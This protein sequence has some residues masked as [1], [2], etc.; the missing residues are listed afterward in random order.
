MAHTT[1]ARV[2]IPTFPVFDSLSLGHRKEVE[3]LVKELSAYGCTFFGDL[4]AWDTDGS[5]EVSKLNNNLVVKLLHYQGEQMVLS[6]L[7]LN[8]IDKTIDQLL[9]FA[10]N[11]NL[12]PRLDSVPEE[13]A[14]KIKAKAGYKITESAVNNE[15]ILDA[16]TTYELPGGQFKGK[17]KQISRLQKQHPKV[18]TIL[19]DPA[20]KK[21]VLEIGKVMDDWA[22][23]AGSERVDPDERIAIERALGAAPT[24]GLSIIGCRDGGRLIAF[25]I[26]GLINRD[27]GVVLFEKA[28]VDYP[29]LYTYL[30]QIEARFFLDNG[31]KFIN[32][33]QDLGIAGIRASKMGWKPVKILKKF[34]LSR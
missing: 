32:I 27:Y 11:N 18:E 9:E 16:K 25:C 30:G 10:K 20:D 34:D 2:P 13:V 28:L 12:P 4:W 23:Q 6:L 31:R 1:D 7:G 19:L 29:G 26:L 14:N 17:R 24:L 5:A 21:T 15:Y 22:G 33:Q 8:D 3:E